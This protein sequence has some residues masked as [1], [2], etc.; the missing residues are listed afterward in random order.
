VPDPLRKL[1]DLSEAFGHGIGV[2]IIVLAVLALD[3]MWRR[4]LARLL[5]CAYG[6]GLAADIVKVFVARTRPARAVLD[7]SVWET[8][9]GRLPVAAASGFAD[10]LKS[11]V[12]SFPSA[13]TATAVGLAVALGFRYPPGRWLFPLL[14]A[15]V[16]LQ[17]VAAGAHFLSDALAGAAIGAMWAALCTDPHAVGRWFDAWERRRQA[18]SSPPCPQ[19][20]LGL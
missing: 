20:R 3:P 16:A 6:A 4:G 10:A 5:V 19:S 18:S 17:R 2:A 14:A 11:S 7:G 13:H 8:F 9:V 15:L 12:E 1:L